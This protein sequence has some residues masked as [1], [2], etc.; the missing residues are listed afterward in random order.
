[1]PS[2]VYPVR[3]EVDIHE[4]GRPSIL[5]PYKREK[6]HKTKLVVTGALR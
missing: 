5:I 3:E 4:M 1:M 2:H 6:Q